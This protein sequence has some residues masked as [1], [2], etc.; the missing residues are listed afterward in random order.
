MGPALAVAGVLLLVFDLHDVIKT[1]LGQR[2]G[3]ITTWISGALWRGATRLGRYG[4]HRML[5]AGGLAAVVLIVV[6][7]LAVLWCAWG[8]IFCG[9]RDAVLTAEGW[10]AAVHERFQYA[11]YA[12]V[13]LGT[14]GGFE[15]G[16]ALWRALTVLAAANGFAVLTLGIAY[17]TPLLSAATE[18]R[19]LALDISI[20]GGSADEIVRRAWNGEDCGALEPHFDQLRPSLTLLAQRYLTYPALHYFHSTDRSS[21]AAPNLA[22]LD[23]ALTL[24]RHGCPDTCRLA[25]HA[26]DTTRR[27]ISTVLSTLR[28]AFVE[29]ADEVPPPPQL[30]A[31]RRAG[32][33]TVGDEEFHAA[34]DELA[35]RRRLLLAL[36]KS[37]GWRWNDVHCPP[38]EADGDN[39]EEPLTEVDSREVISG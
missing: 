7:W 14:P 13:T 3:P 38:D 19:R 27:A 21:A 37:D 25:P 4:T 17:L 28:A 22:A 6:L 11:G 8:L 20:L 16:S 5:Y 33:P 10:P 29:P 39:A 31:L 36:V 1:T 34:L 2:G 12:M 35:D 23:E 32:I 9:A 18:K 24:L 26:L 15:P 30:A